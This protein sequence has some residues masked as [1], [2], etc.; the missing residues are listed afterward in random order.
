MS[1]LEELAAKN[2]SDRGTHGYSIAPGTVTN[3]VDLMSEGMV[4]VRITSMPAVEPWA[5][6]VAVGGGSGRGFFWLPQIG[7]EV[8]VALNANDVRDAYILGGL[9]N[10]MDRPPVTT[11]A[12]QLVKRTIQTGSLPGVGHQVEFDDL[13]QSISIT[14]TTQQKIQLDPKTISLSN[15]AGTVSISMDNTTQTVSITGA[16]KIELKSA[17]ISLQGVKIS[18]SGGTISIQST[19]PC[20]V[21]GLPIKLN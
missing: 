14:T 19:G 3:N 1:A 9:W 16:K 7:D 17:E 5:R 10:T 8:L 11:F 20:T 13:K 15:I 21:Q 4:Q 6:L 18:L 2:S 12:E